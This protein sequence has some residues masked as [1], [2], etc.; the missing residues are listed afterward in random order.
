M[1]KNNGK[2]QRDQISINQMLNDEVKK[3]NKDKNIN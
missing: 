2:N 1:G 3:K